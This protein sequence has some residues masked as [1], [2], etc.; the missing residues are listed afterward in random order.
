MCCNYPVGCNRWF[1][2]CRAV[3]H[4]LLPQITGI[5]RTWGACTSPIVFC[6]VLFF[7]TFP[8]SNIAPPK[9]KPQI[10]QV[11]GSCNQFWTFHPF[12]FCDQFLNGWKEEGAK[13]RKPGNSRLLNETEFINCFWPAPLVHRYFKLVQQNQIL[14]VNVHYELFYLTLFFRSI[15]SNCL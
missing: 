2:W 13:K 15:H 11:L 12:L 5:G 6:L 10:L 1:R 4:F 8:L 7:F 9:T 3:Q 14:D